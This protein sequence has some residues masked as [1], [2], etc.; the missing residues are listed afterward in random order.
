ML[1]TCWKVDYSELHYDSRSPIRCSA[2]LFA[3]VPDVLSR[4]DESLS[5]AKTSCDTILA[6]S[7]GGV[8][9]AIS[10]I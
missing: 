9:L 2:P 10:V 8:C 3:E 7:S 5:I 1:S 4:Q 6:S